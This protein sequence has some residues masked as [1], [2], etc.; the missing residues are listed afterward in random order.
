MPL[1]KKYLCWWNGYTFSVYFVL[2]YDVIGRSWA[3]LILN[4]DNLRS[5]DP[6]SI[7]ILK[8][9]ELHR[10]RKI[11]GVACRTGAI[12]LRFPGEHEA[13]VEAGHARQGKASLQ[14]WLACIT[15]VLWATRGKCGILRES[16]SECKARDE[17]RPPLPRVA[18]NAP[19][20]QARGGR[21]FP[22]RAWRALYV[23]FLL[24]WNKGILEIT[25]VR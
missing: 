23:L 14:A 7:F 6:S 13:D 12:F 11:E 10:S 17:G 15:G 19:V 24:A 8:E 3:P 25:P 5:G 9:T 22:R 1:C 21:T 4:L 2:N 16:Q 18:H 20:M